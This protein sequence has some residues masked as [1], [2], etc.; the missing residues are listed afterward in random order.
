LRISSIL[1]IVGAVFGFLAA[2]L[3][4]MF[5][6][7]MGNLVVNSVIAAFASI[8]GLLGIWLADKDAKIAAVQYVV[9]AIGLLIGTF[10]MGALGALFYVIAAILV[11]RE[12][13]KKEEVHENE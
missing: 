12:G 3:A 5:S 6:G 7:L 9:A 4:A 13:S 11:F 1:A 2:I 8:I 10:L